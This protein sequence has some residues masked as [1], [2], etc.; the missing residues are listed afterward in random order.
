MRVICFVHTYVALKALFKNMKVVPKKAPKQTHQRNIL[1]NIEPEPFY[2]S[3]NQVRLLP[4]E[5]KRVSSI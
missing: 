2:T 1:K 4:I 3:Q 5:E